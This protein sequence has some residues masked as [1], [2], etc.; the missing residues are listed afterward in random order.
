MRG[1]PACLRPQERGDFFFFF[2]NVQLRLISFLFFL[3]INY[4]KKKKKTA[5]VS[6]F[7]PIKV[8]EVRKDR[9]ESNIKDV[10]RSEGKYLEEAESSLS[11]TSG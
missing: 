11:G 6:G 8:G 2:F 10:F 4:I 3:E 5:S 7:S 1:K 9:R